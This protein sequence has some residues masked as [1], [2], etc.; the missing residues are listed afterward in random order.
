VRKICAVARVDGGWGAEGIA[1]GSV[2]AEGAIDASA[3]GSR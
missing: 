2:P 3:G 1:L